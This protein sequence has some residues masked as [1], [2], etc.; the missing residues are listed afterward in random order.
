MRKSVPLILVALIALVLAGC[1]T[2]TIRKIETRF[3][4]SEKRF[5]ASAFASSLEPPE[6]AGENSILLGAVVALSGI[7]QPFDAIPLKGAQLAIADIN[8]RGGVLGRPLELRMVDIKSDL[9]ESQSAAERLMERGAEMVMVSCTMLY[10]TSDIR[11]MRLAGKIAFSSCALHPT[12]SSADYGPQIYTMMLSPAVQS[13]TL[14]DWAFREKGWRNA[15]LVRNARS[16][17]FKSLCDKF[18]TRWQEL[19]GSV[20]GENYY[21]SSPERSHG[22]QSSRIKS[23]NDA[24]FAFLCTASALAHNVSN[25]SDVNN[26][27]T[28]SF[29]L[30]NGVMMPIF[31]PGFGTHEQTTI[32]IG[33]VYD[34]LSLVKSIR[35]NGINLPLIA[36][37]AMDSDFWL[38][39]VPD[40]SDFYVGVNGSKFSNDPDPRINDFVRR[41]TEMFGV[42]PT[43]SHALLG[44]SQVEAW[45]IAAERAGSLDADAIAHELDKFAR[46]PLLIGPTTFTADHQVAPQRGMLIMEVRNGKHVPVGRYIAD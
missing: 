30:I 46:E 40:L 37:A 14:A 7:G 28:F 16:S 36:A 39:D 42:A 33:I 45:A 23:Q 4:D 3:P 6:P 19:G 20:T 35:S 22:G 26:M 31:M 18:K 15:Y 5:L 12:I 21:Q 10:G 27:G 8:A 41:Y 17:H 11:E 43:S 24:D 32:D 34:G 44:Y 38:A 25:K 9:E 2:P 13:A 1:V 29:I